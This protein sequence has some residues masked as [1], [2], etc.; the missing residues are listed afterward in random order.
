MSWPI[1]VTAVLAMLLGFVSGLLT[2]RRSARW[3]PSCGAGLRCPDCGSSEYNRYA[4][5]S[6]IVRRA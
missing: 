6:R 3:C 1:A 4:V 2:I 5:T